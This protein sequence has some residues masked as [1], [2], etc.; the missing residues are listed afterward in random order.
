MESKKTEKITGKSL[1][2]QER[3]GEHL[4]LKAEDIIEDILKSGKFQ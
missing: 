2:K 1:K 4:H 3:F